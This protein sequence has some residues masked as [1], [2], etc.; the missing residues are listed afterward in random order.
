MDWQTISRDEFAELVSVCQRADD[1]NHL[2]CCGK[3]SETK[4]DGQSWSYV[5]DMLG[6]T[7][8]SIK[9]DGPTEAAVY[10]AAG[11]VLSR[12][13]F[14]GGLS[15]SSSNRYD[16]AGRLVESW[17]EAGLS[18]TTEYGERTETVTRRAGA[19]EIMTGFRDGKVKSV[20]GTGVVPVYY[21]YGIGNDG[22]QWTKP[23]R[24]RRTHPHGP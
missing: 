7:I 18:T 10:D 3:E 11:K 8:Y 17:D 15:L 6:R 22:G 21:E 1:G 20:T 9:E 13:L 2:S 24:A 5:Q 23:T 14:G 4:P 16:L 12:T 19:T